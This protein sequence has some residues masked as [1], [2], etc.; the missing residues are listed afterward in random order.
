MAK[1]KKHKP[2]EMN[3]QEATLNRNDSAEAN[4]QAERHQAE[5]MMPSVSICTVT[6]QRQ[7]YLTLVEQCILNQ[8]YPHTKIEWII[9]DDSSEDHPD[10]HPIEQSGLTINYQR[11]PKKLRLGEKRNLSHTF[12]RGDIIIYFDD[13]DYYPPE[14]VEHAVNQLEQSGCMV[15][16]STVLPI[17]FLPDEE[18]WVEGPYDANHATSGTLAFRRALLEQTSHD[19]EAVCLE[20]KSFLKDY[21]IPM[22][23]LEP[24]FTI[25]SIFHGGNIIDKRALIQ[26]V[27]NTRIQRVPTQDPNQIGLIRQ[28]AKA[29]GNAN[30]KTSTEMTQPGATRPV[31]SAQQPSPPMDEEKLRLPA[32]SIIELDDQ[33]IHFKVVIPSFNAERYIEACIRSLQEQNHRNFEAIIID[34]GSIDNT[35]AIASAAIQGDSR[36]R[37]TSNTANSGSP[38]QSFL[39]GTRLLRPSLDD[40]LITLDG[41]DQLLGK[42]AL[43]IVAFTYQS[44]QCLLTYGSFIRASDQRHIGGAYDTRTV[45]TNSFRQVPWRA[46]HLRTFKAGL[47]E[48]LSIGDLSD[49]HGNIIRQAGDIALMHPLLEISGHR[50]VHIPSAIH[51]YNDQSPINEHKVNHQSQAQTSIQIRQR[52]SYAHAPFITLYSPPIGSGHSTTTQLRTAQMPGTC[53]ATQDLSMISVTI[54]TKER[55]RHLI[56]IIRCFQ[57]QTWPNKELLILDD[58]RERCAEAEAIAQSDSRICYIH[59]HHRDSIGTKRKRL[60]AAAKGEYIAHFDDDDYYAPDYLETMLN[61]LVAG[62]YDFVKLRSWCSLHVPTRIYGFCNTALLDSSCSYRMSSSG[63]ERFPRLFSSEEKDRSLYGYGFSYFYRSD[64]LNKA[65]HPEGINHG[66]DIKL[67]MDCISAGASIGL[68]DDYRGLAIHIIHGGNTSSCFAQHLILEQNLTKMTSILPLPTTFLSH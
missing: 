14:R 16:G 1:R 47:L 46:S 51:L 10:F 13:D 41:D 57:S 59:Q 48:L 35:A 29:Y 33:D 44:Q 37:I 8:T 20:E 15:A 43:Q 34:D 68:V 60:C 6:H 42:D 5:G 22:A 25:I 3:Q 28:L 30:C 52:A 66:E 63:I 54:P 9:L 27:E 40:V 56:N 17:L 39:Q 67:A 62:R 55:P 19:D 61:S 12:C 2:M 4:T 58:S 11:L 64:L 23:Q 24:R 36:F 49:E 31:S 65:S 7:A 21:S 18:L 50:A 53:K 32:R 26:Q 45:I 38:L